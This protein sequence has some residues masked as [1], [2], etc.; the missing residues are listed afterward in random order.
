MAQLTLFFKEKPI[1]T[2][3]LDEKPV[4]IGRDSKNT[5]VID[6]L[7]IAP[8][9]LVITIEGDH[10][11]I[12]SCSEQF[13]CQLN[14]EAIKRTRLHHE[15][16]ISLKKHK[17]IFSETTI[18][19]L[20][21]LPISETTE[22]KQKTEH[23]ETVKKPSIKKR[24]HHSFTANLQIINGRDIG[25]VIPLTRPVTEI[26]LG[27]NKNIPAIIVKRNN[28]YYLSR[29]TDSFKIS[30]DG[31]ELESDQQLNDGELIKIDE[32]QFSYFTEQ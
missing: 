17:L 18:N 9:Q 14:G 15:D 24:S 30:I 27:K 22:A 13:P 20:D 29:L 8:E 5:F 21:L 2:F 28:G 6:S 23:T 10:Y 32:H 7:A 19:N 1:D 26:P 11:V 3:L 25:L 31:A 12:E 16:K 4:T